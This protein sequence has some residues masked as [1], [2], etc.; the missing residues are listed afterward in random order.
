MIKD[1]IVVHYSPPHT[2]PYTQNTD[3]NACGL[4]VTYTPN[5]GSDT[6]KHTHRIFH[7]VFGLVWFGVFA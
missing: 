4:Q 5:I 1:I 2:H 3:P 7:K 6:L